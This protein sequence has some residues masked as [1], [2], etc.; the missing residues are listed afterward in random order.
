MPVLLVLVN[1][2]VSVW[3]S[4]KDGVNVVITESSDIVGVSAGVFVLALIV[5][6]VIVVQG[7]INYI[8][9]ISNTGI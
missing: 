4:I 8:V 6:V 3:F 9:L 1:I 7:C 2:P 5:V